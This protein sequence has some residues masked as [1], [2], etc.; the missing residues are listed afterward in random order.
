MIY[1]DKCVVSEIYARNI[2][3]AARAKALYC[4]RL[5]YTIRSMHGQNPVKKWVKNVLF[6]LIFHTFFTSI[7]HAF[8]THASHLCKI[9]HYETY[10]KML[11]GDVS[12]F[13]QILTCISHAVSHLNSHWF[14]KQFQVL[15]HRGFHLNFPCKFSVNG[16][17]ISYASSRKFHL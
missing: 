12:P 7:S 9:L 11:W 6:S 17:R 16:Y 8:H 15:L 14:E 10:V 1:R 3:Y 13:T 4:R 5:T 2:S